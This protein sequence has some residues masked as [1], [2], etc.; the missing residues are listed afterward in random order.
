MLDSNVFDDLNRYIENDDTFKRSNYIEAVLDAG[1]YKGKR[2]LIPL[3]YYS[4][5]LITASEILQE[6]GFARDEELL[7]EVNL[8][9][10]ESYVK[11]HETFPFTSEGG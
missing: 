5:L 4:P 3:S 7:V 8:Q 10:L 1:I 6:E 9:Q 11:R 2:H